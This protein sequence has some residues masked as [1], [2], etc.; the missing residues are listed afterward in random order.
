MSQFKF[1]FFKIWSLFSSNSFIVK[2]LVFPLK[3]IN[4]QN[5]SF[6]KILPLW[7]SDTN[8]DLREDHHS[9]K[10]VNS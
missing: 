2:I 7:S 6:Y 8:R 10:R 5:N 9:P 1:Y 3:V 4:Y